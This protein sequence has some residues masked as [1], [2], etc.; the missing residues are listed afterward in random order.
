MNRRRELKLEREKLAQLD[1]QSMV[2]A[3]VSKTEHDREMLER[4]VCYAHTGL[5]RW[6]V[7]LGHFDEARSFTRCGS[8]DNCVAQRAVEKAIDAEPARIAEAPHDSPHAA[9][10]AGDKV[11]VPRYGIGDVVSA[12]AEKVHIAFPDGRRRSF[13]T[14]YVQIVPVG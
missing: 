10:E 2:A 3:Y 11:S 9:F 12:D 14:E 6:G 5:C 4:M 1:L 8:C 7:L 13:M